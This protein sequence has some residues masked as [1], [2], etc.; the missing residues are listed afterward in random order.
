MTC[1]N[2]QREDTD[3][4]RKKILAISYAQW[5][6][7]GFSKGTLNYIKKTA[8][9]DRPF[10]VYGKMRTRLAGTVPT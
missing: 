2:H 8:K 10:K 3:A 7:M 5:H 9:E 4:L 6:R 1:R